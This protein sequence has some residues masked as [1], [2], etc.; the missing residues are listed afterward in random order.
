MA[1]LRQTDPNLWPLVLQ[2][3]RATAAYHR[4]WRRSAKDGWERSAAGQGGVGF[5]APGVPIRQSPAC[6]R[7]IPR[8]QVRATLRR[9]TPRRAQPRKA[10]V[11]ERAVLQAS[12][13]AA[14]A[15]TAAPTKRETA[16]AQPPS[17]DRPAS[18]ST[19][20]VVPVSYN[21]PAKLDWQTHLAKAIRQLESESKGTCQGCRRNQP[22]GRPAD[23]LS[24]RRSA[25]EDALRP[26]ARWRPPLQDFWSKELYGLATW[27]DA[28]RTPDDRRRAGE[29]KRILSEALARL[30]EM[31]PLAVRNLVFC[32]GVQSYGSVQPFEKDG[33]PARPGSAALRRG[34]QLRSRVDPQGLSTR[35][36]GAATRSSTAAASGSRNTS[37]ATIE[38]YC[39]NP[40][41][42]FFI[43][44]HLRLPKRIYPGK[45]TLK[46]TVEDLKSHRV[47]ES[48]IELVI[49]G[50]DEG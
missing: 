4:R 36:C 25:R 33:V 49:K 48:S 3:F 23:A 24:A 7:W 44:Y 16:L 29:A 39:Q 31:A 38:E 8:R 10:P 15:G 9:K 30:G 32:T 28:E 2:Q 41:R 47:G 40:R 37:S 21:A 6:R 45:H 26:I 34:G 5:H 18:G 13:R 17:G 42:D 35:R 22:A 11:T 1:D 50:G 20:D 27:L 43:G 12:R 19:S 14:A 46:L